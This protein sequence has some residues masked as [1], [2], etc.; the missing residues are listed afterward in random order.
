ML[1][2]N[3]DV[4]ELGSIQKTLARTQKDL[5]AMGTTINILNEKIN[6]ANKIIK[7]ICEKNEVDDELLYE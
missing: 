6:V 1:I 2:L 4:K 7:N 5:L 3:T